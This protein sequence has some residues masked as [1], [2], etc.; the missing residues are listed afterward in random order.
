[1]TATSISTARVK[2]LC[3][4]RYHAAIGSPLFDFDP[5]WWEDIVDHLRDG[6]QHSNPYTNEDD[7]LPIESISDPVWSAHDTSVS[8]GT[9]PS[10]TNVTSD[11]SQSSEPSC[12]ARVD[13]QTWPGPSEVTGCTDWSSYPPQEPRSL[14]SSSSMSYSSSALVSP[15]SPESRGSKRPL[16]V[17]EG[18]LCQIDTSTKRRRIDQLDSDD[19]TLSGLSSGIA[20]VIPKTRRFFID[21]DEAEDQQHQHEGTWEIVQGAWW[22]TSKLVNWREWE[23]ECSMDEGRACFVEAP[24]IV[25]DAVDGPQSA[26]VICVK[27]MPVL[28]EPVPT[29][30]ARVV[31]GAIEVLERTARLSRPRVQ[32]GA[33][34]IEW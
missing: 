12:L 3:D 34:G 11:T 2:D 5:E 1:M 14:E 30:P 26:P 28:R 19:H 25:D 10:L 29:L 18:R 33:Q 20:S 17:D 27:A 13:Q 23:Y 16:G 7:I 8:Y 6:N 4:P 32:C 21:E 31:D 22:D 9:V 24:R 15:T